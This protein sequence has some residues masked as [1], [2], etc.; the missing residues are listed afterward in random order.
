MVTEK[1]ERLSITLG[2]RRGRFVPRHAAILAHAGPSLESGNLRRLSRRTVTKKNR[3]ERNGRRSRDTPLD[4][5][6]VS[7]ITKQA[8]DLKHGGLRY[9]LIRYAFA[10]F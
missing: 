9:E 5:S 8:T 2:P 7:G 10:K 1:V 6:T 3:S 4:Y